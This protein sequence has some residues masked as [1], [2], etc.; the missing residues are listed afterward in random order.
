MELV[1]PLVLFVGLPVVLILFLIR[2]KK[3]DTYRK[4]NKVANADFVESNPYYKKLMVQYKIFGSVAVLSLLLSTWASL[5]MVSRPVEIE[6]VTEEIRNRDIFICMDIS[7]SVDETN[8]ELMDHL[9]TVVSE[10]DGERFG[11]T[12]FNAKSVLLIPLTTDYQ[13]IME[14]LDELEESFKESLVLTKYSEGEP[15][16]AKEY[17][18][19][20]NFDYE[21]YYF[22]YGGTLSEEGSSYIGDGLATCLYN[23]SDLE[24]NPDRARVIIMTTD[25]EL[26]GNPLLSIEEAADLCAKHDV[27]VF[28]VAPDHIANEEQ[29]KTAILSTGGGYYRTSEDKAYEK[30]VNDIKA[31][32]ASVIE[33]TET[34]VY[35]QPEVLFIVLIS[36][37]GV[38]FVF[39]RKVKL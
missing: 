2:F 38:Y 35:D 3:K 37:L 7:G 4:G 11:I 12:I 23:F 6:T 36:L 5:A 31:T 39:S 18:I 8:L 29:F 15:L 25:N 20:L 24:E 32:D 17:D 26:L 19:L 21:K 10:L 28:G 34:I 14:M 13:Y 27:K 1:Y 16:S 9:K 33:K 22:K 30:L